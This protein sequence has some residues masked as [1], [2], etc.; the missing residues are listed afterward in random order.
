MGRSAVS[1]RRTDAA[2]ARELID[3]IGMTNEALAHELGMS[4]RQ[5]YNLRNGTTELRKVVRLAL[6]R[7]RDLRR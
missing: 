2:S 7:V 5:I 1:K 4:E 6:E 3:A